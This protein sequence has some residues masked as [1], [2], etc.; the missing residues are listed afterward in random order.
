VASQLKRAHRTHALAQRAGEPYPGR[1]SPA[2]GGDRPEDAVVLR[3]YRELCA[4][5]PDPADRA[6]RI[7]VPHATVAAWDTG[8]AL[9][10]LRAHR[11]PLERA[12]R[13]S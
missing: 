5:L 6:H 9:P 8:R 12:L 13:T 10:L 3:L 11:R 1:P 2:G 7:G 4:K